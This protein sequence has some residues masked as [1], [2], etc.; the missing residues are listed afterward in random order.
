MHTVSRIHILHVWVS[1]INRFIDYFFQ[2]THEEESKGL[3][4]EI[5]ELRR[6]LNN[7]QS[8]LGTKSEDTS[9]KVCILEFILS[10]FDQKYVY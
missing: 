1:H 10:I 2:S 5:T 3:R 9:T 6:L 4:L 8:S 7:Q